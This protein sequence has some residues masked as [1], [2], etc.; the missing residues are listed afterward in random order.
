M[1]RNAKEIVSTL[2]TLLSFESVYLKDS[3]GQEVEKSQ[4]MLGDK[5]EAEIKEN[6][7]SYLVD[8]VRGQKTGFF[9]D[10]RDNRKLLKE[11]TL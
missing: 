6:N 5:S 10:Q 3:T 4:F 2:T 8:I 7:I 9:L 1:M 11:F